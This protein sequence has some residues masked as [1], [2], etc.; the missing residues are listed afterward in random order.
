MTTRRSL[1]RV[2][3]VVVDLFIVAAC[4]PPRGARPFTGVLP[5]DIQLDMAGTFALTPEGELRLELGAACTMQQA[6]VNSPSERVPC[7][8]EV[9]DQIRVTAHTPWN[10]DIA[11]TWRDA[12]HLAFQ[13]DWK[14]IG[15]DPLADDAAA[16]TARPWKVSGTE[17]Q[18]TAA[19]ATLILE[20]ISAAT[21]T[22]IALARDG[23]APKL[24]ITALQV[25][26]DTLHAGDP[27][28]LVVTVA[29][30]GLGT[31]YRVLAVTRS[32]IDALHGH[33]L[34]FGSIPPGAAKTRTLKLTVPATEAARDTMV[35]VLLTE[36]NGFA[37]PPASRRIP[38]APSTAAPVLVVRC[39]V[40]GRNSA[41]RPDLDAGQQVKLRCMV[42][43]TGN[44]PAQQVELEV[45][46][47][48]SSPSRSAPQVIAAAA[49]LAFDVPVI[50]PRSLPID[51]PVEMTITVRDRVSM[52]TA[53]TSIVG[54]VRKPRLC[55]PGQLTRP[56][57]QEKIANLRTALSDKLLTQAEFDRYDAELVACLK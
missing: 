1:A 23:P 36:G 50:V 6:S 35:V 32:S 14:A 15:V 18:P 52:R 19:E 22:E 24:E 56:Q 3:V 51:A 4:V 41:E 5:A 13:I 12:A 53:R 7:A 26:G 31:A 39:T 49:H 44:A 30:R 9:L 25:E 16:I 20:R 46:V 2:L 48:E 10:Q 55:L 43:N 21:D 28:S 45:A 34:S 40:V 54:V 57:Y 37:P 27:G 42:T 8:R 17:W 38:I 47:G 29:N 33:R 11:G